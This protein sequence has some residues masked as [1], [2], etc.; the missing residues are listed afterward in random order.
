MQLWVVRDYQLLPR[1]TDANQGQAEAGFEYRLRPVKPLTLKLLG[2]SGYTN[3]LGV[4]DGVGS[5]KLYKYWHMDANPHAEYSPPKS[6]TYK[7]DYKF[8]RLDY[9]DTDSSPSL[10]NHQHE[11]RAAF[12]PSFGEDYRSSINIEGTYLLKNYQTLGSYDSTG[13]YFDHPLRTYHYVSIELTVKHDFGP[14]VAKVAYRPRSCTDAFADFY[15]YSEHRIYGNISGTL[16]SNT[17][18]ALD[19]S[20]RY[21]HYPV[22]TAPQPGTNRDPD[23][24]MRYFDY[25][26][27]IE[28]PIGKRLS[29]FAAYAMTLRRTNTGIL[30][31]YTFRNYTDHE[32]RAGVRYGW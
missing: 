10:D 19:G 13:T 25:S 32:V 12:E 26:A 4:D 17:S 6:F 18:F 15:S 30:Y 5:T 11:L 29:L 14:V 9:K 2:S 23:L 20:W 8:S 1:Y 21:R 22:H 24:V 31:F 3:K 27:D 7:F 28:Q 16:P